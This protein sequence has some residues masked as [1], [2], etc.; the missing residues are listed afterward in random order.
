MAT[1]APNT[2][3]PLFYKELVPLSS[4]VHGDYK[5]RQADNAMFASNAHAI[6][7][8][9]DEFVACQRF[10]PIVF[11]A[12]ES[13]VPLVLMGLNEGVN[14]FL[15]EDGKLIGDAYV[16][17]YI[18]RY[19]FMLARIRPDAE[20]LS[21]CFDPTSGLVG[22]FEDGTPLFDNGNPSEV[23]NRVL[24]FCEEFELAA[25]RTNSFMKDLNDAGLLMDGEVSLQPPGSDKPFL[26]RGFKMVSDEKLRDLRGD[27]LR[28]MNQN[29]MLPLITAHLFSLGLVRE[30][31][32][33]QIAQGK[34]PTGDVPVPATADA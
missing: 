6:P 25:Q 16:P 14:V 24:K 8:T 9:V 33:K 32:G 15:G 7:I 10:Y 3:L 2:Q 19:P 4:N 18:R 27:E 12:G 29:G 11:S 28:K 21:L 22:P 34:M 20:E 17:A 23:T 31:F 1:A 26:Y 13:P 5:V 30:V